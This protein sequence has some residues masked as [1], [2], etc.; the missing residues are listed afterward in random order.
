MAGPLK[1]PVVSLDRFKIKHCTVTF[2]EI[3]T[4]WPDPAYNNV[5]ISV[6]LH[7]PNIRD[8]H[9]LIRTQFVQV[10]T[11]GIWEG[12]QE[13]STFDITEPL[14]MARAVIRDHIV[15]ALAHE[16]DEW[17]TVNGVRV[18]PHHDPKT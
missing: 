9:H 1:F 18:A 14:S 2:R 6:V 8:P 11:R 4:E 12:M 5:E 16:V 15:H 10:M 13:R 3:P 17:L 7:V